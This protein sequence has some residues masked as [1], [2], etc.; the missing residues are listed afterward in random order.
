MANIDDQERDLGAF[1][2]Q[3]N[4]VRRERADRRTMRTA[5]ALSEDERIA[6][7][8][9]QANR[10]RIRQDDLA[11]AR[12]GTPYVDIEDHEE[13]E[14]DFGARNRNESNH[15]SFGTDEPYPLLGG[16]GEPTEH[17]VESQNGW[18]YSSST[19]I[20][21]DG[22]A[23]RSRKSLFGAFSKNETFALTEM[24]PDKGYSFRRTSKVEKGPITT[25]EVKYREDGKTKAR[26]TLTDRLPLL[27]T[28]WNRYDYDAHGNKTLTGFQTPARSWFADK[29]PGGLI[30]RTSRREIGGLHAST[31]RTWSS[32]DENGHV[33]TQSALVH[34]GVGPYSVR[35]SQKTTY[36]R[37]GNEY[38]QH[39][40]THSVGKSGWLFKRSAEFNPETGKKTVTTTFFGISRKSRPEPMTDVEK[41]KVAKR[42]SLRET[43]VQSSIEADGQIRDQALQRDQRIRMV[44]AATIY[45]LPQAGTVRR[46]QNMVR[47][48]EPERPDFARARDHLSREQY[49]AVGAWVN[50][51]GEVPYAKAL[52]QERERAAGTEKDGSDISS[53]SR[54]AGSSDDTFRTAR[55]KPKRAGKDNYGSNGSDTSSESGP[56]NSS[57][58]SRSSSNSR[59]SS[60]TAVDSGSETSSDSGSS[61]SSST[62]NGYRAKSR[63]DRSSTGAKRGSDASDSASESSFDSTSSSSSRSS[64]SSASTSDDFVSATSG[65]KE[66]EPLRLHDDSRDRTNRTRG[67]A[68]DGHSI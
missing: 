47:T 43:S 6:I 15:L 59:S 25:R 41:A 53:E 4:E 31:R 40:Q 63:N 51:G 58:S 54:S 2:A 48:V 37:E 35:W 60:D 11:R 21:E 68:G 5:A 26:E 22:I 23:T 62:G 3:R 13:E 8:E 36:D 29:E 49:R 55:R 20:L 32:T 38:H 65:N 42:E 30:T 67:R 46:L 1:E 56:S 57:R 50:S 10:E 12:S 52:A 27:G 24:H 64:S 34:R 33:T 61:S 19:R 7:L 17:V 28:Y 39:V 18:F 45:R 66:R 44:D 16:K 9:E 14:A